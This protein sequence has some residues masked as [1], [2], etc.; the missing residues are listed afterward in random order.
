MSDGSVKT[1]FDH[2]APGGPGVE[3]NRV[4][5]IKSEHYP[6]HDTLPVRVTP[7]GTRMRNAYQFPKAFVT[8]LS[9]TLPERGIPEIIL[10]R[11][12]TE[13]MTPIA[14]HWLIES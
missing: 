8:D 14:L 11:P 2:P 1:F 4:M 12:Y 7:C 10:W 13:Y 9:I 3:K 5:P 6:F